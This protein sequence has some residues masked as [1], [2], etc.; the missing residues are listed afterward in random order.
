MAPLSLALSAFPRAV[1]L[2]ATSLVLLDSRLSPRWIGWLG[3]VLAPLSLISTAT[4]VIGE[5]F[6]FLA[7]G[8]LIFAI[9]VLALSC[10]LLWSTR[11]AS[12]TIA[13][14]AGPERLVARVEA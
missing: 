14:V 3:L 13:H 6:P 2:G 7:I 10:S 1:L 5:L 4:L 9:W 12:K 8:T 11:A